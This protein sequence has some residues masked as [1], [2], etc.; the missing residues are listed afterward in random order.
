MENKNILLVIASV[1]LFLI[2]VVGV[3][4]WVFWPKS[5]DGSA[6]ETAAVGTVFDEE[7]D[8]FEFYKGR[9]ELPGILEKPEAEE[10]L[11]TIGEVESEAPPVEIEEKP[12]TQV[13]KPAVTTVVQ[14]VVKR[15]TTSVQTTPPPPKKVNVKEYEIQVGSY[16]SRNRAETINKTL[17]EHGLSGMIHTKN[18]GSDTY[19]RVRIGPYSNQL[20]AGKFLDWIKQIGGLE[21]SYISQVTRVRTVQ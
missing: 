8:S 6:A 13:T 5:L 1:S 7:F 17:T 4:L 20:E 12:V 15:Q 14:P 11:L 9:D 21:G 18:I 2:I 10:M 16:K 19:F 3:G